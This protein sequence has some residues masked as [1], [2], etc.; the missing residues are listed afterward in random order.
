MNENILKK[1]GDNI[2]KVIVGKRK[3]IDLILTA[4]VKGGHVLLEEIGRAHV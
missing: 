1:A 2:E 3:V 4:L